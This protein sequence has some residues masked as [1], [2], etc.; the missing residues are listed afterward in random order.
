ADADDTKYIEVAGGTPPV[1]VIDLFGT[2]LQGL[3]APS[4]PIV[5]VGAR[6]KCSAPTGS[7][8]FEVYVRCVS[9]QNAIES[10]P[11][12]YPEGDREYAFSSHPSNTVILLDGFTT[13]PAHPTNPYRHL[14]G[15]GAEFD[16]QQERIGSSF[17]G[18]FTP[19]PVD[20]LFFADPTGVPWD[21][22]SI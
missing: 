12:G 7:P 6:A 3:V 11:I 9:K 17:S 8:P 1:P 16:P 4:G 13:E 20:A 2:V 22:A 18:S 14:G 5:A 10:E 21:F 19:F 15:P